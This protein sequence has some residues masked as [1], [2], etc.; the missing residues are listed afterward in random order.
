MKPFKDILKPYKERLNKVNYKKIKNDFHPDVYLFQKWAHKV[1]KNWY[2]FALG[3]TVPLVWAQIIDD[4]LEELNKVA[5]DFEIHQ[6]KLKFGGL[7]FYVDLKE[8]SSGKDYEFIHHA[9][10]ELEKTLFSKDLIY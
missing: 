4:F 1:G 6:M 5:P 2:G 10:D 3:N 7:R 9:I 8:F